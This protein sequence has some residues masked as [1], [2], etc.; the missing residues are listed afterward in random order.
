MSEIVNLNRRRKAKVRA[1][2]VADAAK[3]RGL[4]GLTKSEKA[5][6]RAL[7]SQSDK[8]LDSLRRDS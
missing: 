2:A 7:K 5:T 8:R 1:E 3:N 4:F 6:A